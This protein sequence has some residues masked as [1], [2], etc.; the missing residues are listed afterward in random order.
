ML[1]AILAVLKDQAKEAEKAKAK[2]R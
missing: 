1:E 2:K